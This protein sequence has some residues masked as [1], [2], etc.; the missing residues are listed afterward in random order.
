MWS[1]FLTIAL[2]C[3]GLYA[4]IL[5]AHAGAQEDPAPATTAMP[6]AAV[7]ADPGPSATATTAPGGSPAAAHGAAPPG[8]LAA[9]RSGGP[10]GPLPLADRHPAG[11]G[12]RP[13][14]DRHEHPG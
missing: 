12:A 4:A 14:A 2:L 1:R 8:G 10:A 13:G 3:T 7:S 11:P 5:G 9:S 6:A